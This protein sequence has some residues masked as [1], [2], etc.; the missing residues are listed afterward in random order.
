MET[1]WSINKE[2]KKKNSELLKNVAIHLVEK[3]VIEHPCNMGIAYLDIELLAA[4]Y[5][6]IFS[7]WQE[8]SHHYSYPSKEFESRVKYF[9]ERI[10]ERKAKKNWV[11]PS[12]ATA[13]NYPDIPNLFFTHRKEFLRMVSS[14]LKKT[15]FYLPVATELYFQAQKD[16]RNWAYC[17]L[18]RHSAYLNRETERTKIETSYN[19]NGHW[20]YGLELEDLFLC[21]SSNNYFAVYFVKTVEGKT[22]LICSAC[23]E[24]RHAKEF[25]NTLDSLT[26]YRRKKWGFYVNPFLKRKPKA[27]QSLQRIRNNVK[28]RIEK[29]FPQETEGIHTKYQEMVMQVQVKLN[30]DQLLLVSK[31]LNDHPQFQHLA[32]IEYV[33]KVY[34]GQVK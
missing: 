6:S 11:F 22:T 4:Q 29:S 13:Y 19:H 1:L 24:E 21:I 26:K 16:Q 7:D 10:G 23:K 20:N 32:L 30:E 17:N 33:D 18:S 25:C 28:K 3:G 15:V 14:E 8:I 9:S 2:E 34:K 12:H 27:I 5:V 31:Y